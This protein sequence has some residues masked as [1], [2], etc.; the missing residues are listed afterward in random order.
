MQAPPLDKRYLTA[1][2]CREL[3]CEM[4][5]Q[6]RSARLLMQR[7]EGWARA[8]RSR[9]D[10]IDEAELHELEAKAARM[11]ADEVANPPQKE[12][13]PLDPWALFDSI[14]QVHA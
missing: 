8:L 10:K 11:K 6:A 4:D 7:H 1:E 12:L 13:D 5:R 3:A 2:G 9:A 14:F